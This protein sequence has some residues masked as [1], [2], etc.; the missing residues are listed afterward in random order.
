MRILILF[1]MTSLALGGED[2]TQ[3][4]EREYEIAIEIARKNFIQ[5]LQIEVTNT[6]KKGNLDDAIKIRD[7]IK[8]L[9]KT[10]WK[11]IFESDNPSNWNSKTEL[12]I[13]TI[14]YL[15][16]KR[17]DTKEYV[18]IKMTKENLNKQVVHGNIGWQGTN[19]FINKAHLLGIFRVD[20]NAKPIKGDIGIISGPHNRG[21]GFGIRGYLDDK[22]GFSWEGKAI[23]KTIMQIAIKEGELTLEEKK[24]LL[25]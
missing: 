11:I 1:I 25:R 10:D 21:W 16:L 7:K 5:K 20:W 12:E 24:F 18:I 19:E 17:L 6:T 2:P 23:E 8:E 14:N 3:K 22:Q 15:L 9:Q 13:Q 4:A